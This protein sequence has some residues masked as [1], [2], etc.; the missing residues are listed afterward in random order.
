M[1]RKLVLFLTLFFVEIG[2]ATGISQFQLRQT[3][4]WSFRMWGMF[5]KKYR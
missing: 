4:H 2:L 1:K 3:E 5:R